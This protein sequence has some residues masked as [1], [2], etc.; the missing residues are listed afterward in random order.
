MK[1]LWILILITL[2]LLSCDFDDFEFYALEGESRGALCRHE[3]V[4]AA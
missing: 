4:M 3:A 2:T 1:T